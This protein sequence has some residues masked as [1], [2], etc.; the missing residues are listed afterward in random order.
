[1]PSQVRLCLKRRI[2]V[3]KFFSQKSV[4]AGAAAFFSVLF[5]ILR[6][7]GLDGHVH[8]SEVLRTLFVVLTFTTFSYCD[9]ERLRA[10]PLTPASF[11]SLVIDAVRALAPVLPF[12][13]VL[14]SAVFF[15]GGSILSKF[16]LDPELSQRMIRYGECNCIAAVTT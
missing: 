13:L 14:W 12:V 15:V 10:R 2:D 16:G 1:L 6:W 4:I 3:Q 7:C 8:H 11:L 5:L 9:V